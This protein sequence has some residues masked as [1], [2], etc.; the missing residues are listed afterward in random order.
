M[1]AVAILLALA[2]PAHAYEDRETVQLFTAKPCAAAVA[3]I[4]APDTTVMGAAE[5]A[6]AWGFLLGVDT[7]LGGLS[8]ATA[9]TLQR[10]RTDC[11]AAPERSALDILRG[12]RS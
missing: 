9:T 8:T 1:R 2:A 4:D 7:M 10:L 3:A 5:M 12:M 6:A 11:A